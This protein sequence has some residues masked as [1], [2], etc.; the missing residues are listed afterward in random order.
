M[1]KNLF[2]YRAVRNEVYFFETL[3]ES[4]L[5]GPIISQKV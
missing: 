5:Y 3:G 1:R 4:L 2:I